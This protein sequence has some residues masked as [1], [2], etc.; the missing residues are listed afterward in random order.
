MHK[1]LRSKSGLMRARNVLTREERIDKLE[2]KEEWTDEGSV[3]GLPK[4][5]VET[6]TLRRKAKAGEDAEAEGEAV[7]AAAGPGD[8]TDGEAEAG[9]G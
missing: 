3:F 9:S 7:E 5:K 1:S 4:V 6:I 8:E 2:E